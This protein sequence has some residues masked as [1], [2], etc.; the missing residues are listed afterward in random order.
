MIENMNDVVII[1]AGLGGLCSAI[2][3][4][5]SGCKVILFEK[6]VLP[7]HKVC[8]E[9]ISN[10]IR[11][12]LISLGLNPKTLNCTEISNFTLYGQKGKPIKHNLKMGGFGVSRYALDYALLKIA[13]VEGVQ[14]INEE[15]IEI[16]EKNYVEVKTKKGHTFNGKI[17]ISAAGKRSKIDTKLSRNFMNNRTDWIGVKAHYKGKW[18]NEDVA[19]FQFDGGY[20]GISKV[21]SD[22]INV[23]Y[24]A[25]VKEF[26]KYNDFDAFEKQVMYANPAFKATLKKMNRIMD[27][28]VISQIYFGKKEK[29]KE[30]I[31]FVGDAAG[32]IYPLAGNGMAMAIHAA[33]MYSELIIKYLNGN[34]SLQ[35][36]QDS[37]QKQWNSKFQSRLVTS[38]LLQNIMGH[39]TFSRIGINVLS[40]FPFLVENL[41]ERTHGKPISAYKE[42]A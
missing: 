9:Y 3:L 27:R 41:I 5:K 21:E 35:T 18:N 22:N 14:F 42:I 31:G 10:E 26:K 36:A 15:V 4:A 11:P 34:I 33:K 12:Y 1:G 2:H 7:R 24:L 29:V 32:M 16:A 20:C 19:L 23:C 28:K 30:N 40:Y 38:Y 17:C 8:G 6:Q 13:K 37:Y 25:N 39:P